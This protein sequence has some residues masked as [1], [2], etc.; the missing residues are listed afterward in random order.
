MALINCPYCGNQVSDKAEICVHCGKSLTKG[1]DEK[2]C[3]ECGTVLH[4]EDKVCPKCGC[5]VDEGNKEPSPVQIERTVVDEQK[6]DKNKYIIPIIIVVVIIALVALLGKKTGSTGNSDNAN[7][8]KQEA[9]VETET[10]EDK[11]VKQLCSSWMFSTVTYLDND[12]KTQKLDKSAFSSSEAPAFK[13][14]KDGSYKLKLLGDEHYVGTWNVVSEDICAG[15]S[16]TEYAY[17][18]ST[19]ESA[20]NKDSIIVMAFIKT[21]DVDESGNSHRIS[22]GFTVDGVA[23]IVYVFIK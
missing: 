8:Q 16:D 21:E 22:V 3:S 17:E 19:D 2:H 5:P 13:A 14:N 12:G 7:E 4:K 15:M 20:L 11:A 1:T 10:F 9:Q 6:K 18:L 23:R